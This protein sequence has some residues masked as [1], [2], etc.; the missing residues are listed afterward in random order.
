MKPKGCCYSFY[1][2][3]HPVLFWPYVNWFP[4]HS[5][6]AHYAEIAGNHVQNCSSSWV[7]TYHIPDG[8]GTSGGTSTAS[9]ARLYATSN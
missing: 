4:I 2:A 3:S 8:D 1:I 5:S 9:T 6:Y 7:T